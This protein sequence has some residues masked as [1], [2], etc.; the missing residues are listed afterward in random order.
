MSLI[1][2]WEICSGSWRG[3]AL[4]NGYI[5]CGTPR[6]G[7]TLLCGLLASTKR[8]GN[9]DSYYRAQS[10][11][12][13]AQEW[14]LPGLDR[15]NEKEFYTVFLQAALK[16]GKDQS[17]FFGL[18]LM[19]ETLTELAAVLEQLFGPLPLDR[20]LF[21]QAFG[22][23]LYIHLSRTDKLA[24]AVSLVKAQQTGLWHVAPDG[25]EI[26]RLAP[27]REP[28]YDFDRIKREVEI[29]KSQDSNWTSWFVEQGIDPYRISYENLADNPTA[30]LTGICEKL[31]VRTCVFEEVTPGVARLG[32]EM[33]LDWMRRYRLEIAGM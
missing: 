25:A 28:Q 18:R 8:A 31:G 15:V 23:T 1:A 26:E 11:S 12:R 13:W 29:L 33:S 5:I 22:K 30:I 19:W 16:A 7:S 21:E 24:Q 14:G 17:D 32:N 2:L 6:T 27:P 20:L 10:I 9:P 4:F 3:E